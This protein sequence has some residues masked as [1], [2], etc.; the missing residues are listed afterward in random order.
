MGQILLKS[1]PHICYWERLVLVNGPKSGLK[2][3]K[4]AED[5]LSLGKWAI[6]K[7]SN[8]QNFLRSQLHRK[9]GQLYAAQGFYDIAV[10]ELALDVDYCNIDILH[11]IG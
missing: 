2:Q 7:G 1:F 3:Y 6:L 9:F 11:V 5:Y 10:E 4:E 8:C